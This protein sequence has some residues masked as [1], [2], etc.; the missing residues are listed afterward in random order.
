MLVPPAASL[1]LGTLVG[2]SLLTANPLLDVMGFTP[3]YPFASCAY[4]VFRPASL[5]F[6]GRIN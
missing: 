2:L 4:E 3:G 6:E 1:I 5:A